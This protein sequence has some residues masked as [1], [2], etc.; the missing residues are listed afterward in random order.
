MITSIAVIS[1]LTSAVWAQS[2]FIPSGISAPCTTFLDK[3]NDDSSMA[4]CISPLLSATAAFDPTV[5]HRPATVASVSSALD[6]FCSSS[7]D[8]AC[9][10]T[11]IR[12]KLADFYAA[13][14][15]ELT[16]QLDK[17]VLLDYDILYAIMPLKDAVCSKDD[18]GKYC[19]TE[20][21][22]PS[23][24]SGPSNNKRAPGDP[25]VAFIPNITTIGSTNLL[26]LY[27]TGDLPSAQLCTTCTKNVLSA[28]IAWESDVPYAPGLSNS[29]LLSGQISLYQGVTNTCGKSFLGGAVQAAGGIASSG[30][31]GQS[32]Q[33]SAHANNRQVGAAGVVAGLAAIAFGLAL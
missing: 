4:A 26:F 18:S 25:Q 31:F 15:A 32:Q 33:N 22:A 9:P 11:L 27:L 23:S 14:N 5:S 3:L 12:E 1:L 13:C 19:A 29:L 17:T 10:N 7:T 28:Y 16:D 2:P 20:T 8:A 21:T 6:T 24:A 30:P